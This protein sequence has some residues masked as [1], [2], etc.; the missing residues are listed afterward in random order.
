MIKNKSLFILLLIFSVI[1]SIYNYKFFEANIGQ[2]KLQRIIGSGVYDFS[3]EELSRWSVDYPSLNNT[4]IPIKSLLG[5]YYITHDSI[6]KGVELLEKG[7][8]ENPFIGYEDMLRAK[9]YESLGEKD[10]FELYARSANRKLPNSAAHYILL[11]RLY[12]QEQK[13]DSLEYYFNTI[14]RNTRDEE[15]WKVYLTT[16]VTNKK[17]T[18]SI[19]VKEN[20]IKA[21]N[22]FPK[23]EQITLSA[24]YVLH[25]I[26]NVKKSIKL[27]QQAIDSFSNSPSKSIEYLKDALDLVPDNIKNYESL[28][29]I[30]FS[31]EKYREIINI[32]NLL[33]EM[34]LTTFGLPV[35]EYI[36]LSYL[37]LQDV[38]RG[39]YL[40]NLL[41]PYGYEVSETANLICNQ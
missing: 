16:M 10:S 26:E 3:Q 14:S 34:K 23:N 35:I 2:R 39:C 25:G 24:N 17:F 9:L 13:I 11:A 31:L 8:S 33:N 32:Y 4:A 41:K 40:I 28:I 36:G 37:N 12:I 27:R 20:A 38:E 29:E 30:L 18:D 1:S 6:I 5:A 15:V 21:K 22:L 7:S 19:N